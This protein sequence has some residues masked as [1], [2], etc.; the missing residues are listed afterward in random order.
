M[1]S[2]HSVGWERVAKATAE[3][4]TA[5][6]TLRQSVLV[7]QNTLERGWKRSTEGE[8]PTPTISRQDEYLRFRDRGG[9]ASIGM[10]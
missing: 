4:A 9:I 5:P 3:G 1:I 6:E 8:S 10:Q 2:V 7:D